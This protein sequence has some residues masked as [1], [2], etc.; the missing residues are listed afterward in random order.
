MSGCGI[1]D[2]EEV[3]MKIQQNG[4]SGAGLKTQ[5]AGPGHETTRIHKLARK[6]TGS[7]TGRG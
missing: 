4:A 5:C 3:A 1:V 2:Y 7:V 6:Y